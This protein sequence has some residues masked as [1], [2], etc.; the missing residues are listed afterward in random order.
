VALPCGAVV[1]VRE[2]QG[3]LVGFDL[4]SIAHSVPQIAIATPL[5]RAKRRTKMTSSPDTCPV[6]LNNQRISDLG[7]TGL[8]SLASAFQTGVH[9]A[10]GVL[11]VMIEIGRFFLAPLASWVGRAWR[12]RGP[13]PFLT[14]ATS[15]QHI[16]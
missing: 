2:S 5:L 16:R 11:Q 9:D 8:A 7:A 10:P 14:G 12:W 3:E 15:L 4:S 1:S 13:S 6:A